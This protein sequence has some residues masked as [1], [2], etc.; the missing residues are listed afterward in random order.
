MAQGG[1]AFSVKDVEEGYSAPW[2]K[3]RRGCR[4]Q[5]AAIA[6]L[7]EEASGLSGGGLLFDAAMQCRRLD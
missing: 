5:Y 3:P 4:A 6:G 2:R 7:R 1:A